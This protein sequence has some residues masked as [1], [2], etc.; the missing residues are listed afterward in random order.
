VKEKVERSWQK[1]EACKYISNSDPLVH[2]TSFGSW[3]AP[4]IEKAKATFL[5]CFSFSSILSLYLLLFNL[6]HNGFN[7][8]GRFGLR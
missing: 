3:A 7:T 4:Q 2:V 6:L 5:S 8:L 1:I